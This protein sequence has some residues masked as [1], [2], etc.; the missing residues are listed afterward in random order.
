MPPRKLHAVTWSRSREPAEEDESVATCGGR[1]SRIIGE[2]VLVGIVVAGA[3]MLLSAALAEPEINGAQP[4]ARNYQTKT[5]DAVAFSP[6]GKTLAWCGRDDSILLW[7]VGRVSPGPGAE[8]VSLPHDAILYSVAFSPDGSLLV[9]GGK[10]SLTI[11]ACKS[12]QYTQLVQ[13]ATETPRCLSFSADGRTLATGSDDGV[14]RLWDM[15]SAGERAALRVH[16]NVV[17]SVAFS[18]DGRRLVSSAQD[19]RI[20]LWDTVRN[21]AIRSFLE[22]TPNPVRIVAFSPDGRDLAVGEIGSYPTD[23]TVL[24]LET[25]A[26]RIRLTGHAE[27][28]N[29]VAFSADGLTLATA[30]IDRCIKLWDL[31]TG[32]ETTTLDSGVGFVKSLAFSRDGAWLASAGDG[33]TIKI[34]DG[35]RR[36]SLLL[37]HATVPR[38]D[39]GD[40]PTE[41]SSPH[42]STSG[43]DVPRHIVPRTRVISPL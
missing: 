22:E 37:G 7:D 19:A 43:F 35:V 4:L 6:D 21:T 8:P 1:L 39:G 16:E 25:G 2:F 14:V 3:T 27:G 17:R 34:W 28:V 38:S 32:K 11:W 12:G 20:I 24:D 30:G 10:D 33:D 29:A 5:I 9:A 40:D 31:V 26:V 18:P 36:R 42:L 15:P 41:S 13:K 23:V